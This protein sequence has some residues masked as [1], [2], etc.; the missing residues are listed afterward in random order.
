MILEG[1][2]EKEIFEDKLPFRIVSNDEDFDY[3]P[4]WHNAIEIIYPVEDN[5]TI[6]V[7][8]KEYVLAENDIFIIAAGDIHSFHIHNNKGI[9]YIVQL[10]LLKLK[11]LNKGANGNMNQFRTCLIS[12]KEDKLI[13]SLLEEQLLKILHEQK[14]RSDTTD[15]YFYARFFDIAVI[16]SSL[17]A[18]NYALGRNNKMSELSKLDKAFEYIHQNYQKQIC[19][20][21]VAAF[22]GYSDYYFS[23]EFKKATEKNFHNYLNE[24][25]IEQ[26]E[27]LLL[28]GENIT[29]AAYASGFNS[30]VTFNRSFRQ[31]KGCSPR[32]FIQKKV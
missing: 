8:K 17:F 23:R 1:I 22:V 21:E 11:S 27:K 5:C 20:S 10:D 4:H 6:I 18:Q 25:R 2:H 7:N 19:L 13:H 3:P 12:S 26:A 24:Y 29:E 32:E 28:A 9:R 15:L 30:L 14:N 31:V 16:L